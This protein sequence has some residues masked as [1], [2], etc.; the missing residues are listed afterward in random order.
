M[1]G[2]LC[3]GDHLAMRQF[4][5]QCKA[6][7]MSLGHAPAPLRWLGK[8]DPINGQSQELKK[9][10]ELSDSLADLHSVA[11]KDPVTAGTHVSWQV[12]ELVVALGRERVT[13]EEF[14]QRVQAHVEEYLDGLEA[15]ARR[16]DCRAIRR[17]LERADPG[18][19]E[20]VYAY[21]QEK[22]VKWLMSR[23]QALRRTRRGNP[24][25]PA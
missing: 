15:A 24:P 25:S 17:D 3:E 13:C 10:I 21:R 16:G 20:V 22:V 9:N 4:S 1:Y 2:Y 5:E 23:P 12:R 7:G 19:P 18:Q 8:N 14:T 11:I 6:G